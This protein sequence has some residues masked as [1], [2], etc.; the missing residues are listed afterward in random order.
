MA[1]GFI[2]VQRFPYRWANQLASASMSGQTAFNYPG[3]SV[4]APPCLCFPSSCCFCA[5][6]WPISASSPLLLLLLH[7]HAQPP[8]LLPPPFSH[9]FHSLLSSKMRWAILLP[10]HF[11]TIPMQTFSFINSAL[12]LFLC[13][14]VKCVFM[15][16]HRFG[17]LTMVLCCV[18]QSYQ[19]AIVKTR[20]RD[21]NR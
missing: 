12:L 3:C 18:T 11:N 5:S 8:S 15:H 4:Y 7:H 10:L 1:L 21:L 2:V 14:C 19:Q 17:F 13:K 20:F 6:Q 16:V 9:Y